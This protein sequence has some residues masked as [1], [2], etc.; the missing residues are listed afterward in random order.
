MEAMAS[1]LAIIGTD[2]G[3]INQQITDNGW[4]IPDSR[5]ETIQA[6]LES[7]IDISDQDLRALKENS[8]ARVEK[9]FLW[10]RVIQHKIGCLE[11]VFGGD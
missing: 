3:A 10:E 4:L 7:A 2:V 1:G 6:A 5:V 9:F 11:G 8:L